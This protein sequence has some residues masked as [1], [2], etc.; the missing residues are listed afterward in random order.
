MS[1]N[2]RL[3]ESIDIVVATPPADLDSA[4]SVDWISL[5]NY[6][7][8]LVV[9]VMA[10]GTAGSDPS[11]ILLQATA[12]AGTS[13][14]ALNCIRK[15]YY[16]VGTQTGISTF[17]SL[18]ITTAT[19]DIDTVSVNGSV[20]LAGDSAELLL[21]VDVRASDLDVDNGFDCLGGTW[22]DADIAATK[23]GTI[24]YIPYGARY[25]GPVPLTAITD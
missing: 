6:E 22:D 9:L 1:L 18:A 14:K 5:K 16:K 23:Y 2:T 24:L 8:C 3:L 11:I 13:S 17:S 12:V 4:A 21:V 20:D 7:G 10:A 15:I 25:P 19:G